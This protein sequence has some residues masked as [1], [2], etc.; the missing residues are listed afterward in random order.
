[1]PAVP[2]KPLRRLTVKTK[3]EKGKQSP[4]TVVDDWAADETAG[5]RRQVYLITLPHPK[6]SQSACGIKLV[7]PGSLSKN[8]ILNCLLDA[9]KNPAYSDGKSLALKSEVHLKQAGVF[10]ELHQ[11]DPAGDVN[12]HVHV[13]ALAQ[14][15]KQF[16]FLPVK[17][18]LLARHGLATH[19]S[20]THIGYWSAIRYVSVRSPTKPADALDL[21][22]EL[23]AAEGEHPPLHMCRDEPMT[24]NALRR[25]SDFKYQKAAE[26][27]K[28]EKVTELDVWPIVVENG[29]RNGPDEHIAHLKLAAYA[30][31]HCSKAVQAFLFKRRHALPGLIESIW[32]WETVDAVLGEATLSRVGALHVAASGACI[33]SGLWAST[34]VQSVI[35][36]KIN[37]QELCTDVFKALESGRSETTPVVVLA[38]ASGGEG[39]SFFLKPLL[40]LLGDEYIFHC[41]EPG[42]F[43]LL[44]L[45]GKKVVFLDD[46]RFNKCVLPFETQCRWFD[47]SAVRVQRPQNQQGATG[48]V[49]YQGTAPIFVTTKLADM[50]RFKKL[51]AI[52][53]ATGLALDADASMIYRRLKVYEFRK[54]ITKAPG[55]IKYC[56]TCFAKLVL[57]QSGN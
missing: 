57:S 6:A 46:W 34:V 45:P 8:Q 11:P 37:L 55:K 18:A 49:T 33:C 39:K 43:P 13:A 26:E 19:W 53:P 42:T 32:Q 5:A 3:F 40:T 47:G 10:R 15:K 9:C 48:H 17:K 30:K 50:E 22:P 36:N 1:M 28:P 21:E 4:L 54:R 7:L 16:Y 52:D 25:I 35:E 23:W 20:C 27:G 12:A 14:P 44:D 51:S 41:P 56:P 38:G 31:H 2:A 24:A 29:F